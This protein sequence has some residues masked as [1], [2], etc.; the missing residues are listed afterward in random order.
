MCSVAYQIPLSC[1]D[2]NYFLM[3]LPIK[4]VVGAILTDVL[5]T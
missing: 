5:S 3:I 1:G 4:M 2:Y